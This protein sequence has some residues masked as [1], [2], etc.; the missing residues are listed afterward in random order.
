MQKDVLEVLVRIVATNALFILLIA[1]GD[2]DCLKKTNRIELFFSDEESN[3]NKTYSLSSQRAN[4][5]LAID[6]M[7]HFEN[8]KKTFRRVQ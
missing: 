4:S 1:M 7:F 2:E 5:D 6:Q 8:L 3:K